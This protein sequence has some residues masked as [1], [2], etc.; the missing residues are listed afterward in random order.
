MEP[1]NDILSPNTIPLKDSVYRE[2]ADKSDTD[3]FRFTTPPYYRDIVEVEIENRS[4][5]LAPELHV[6]NQVKSEI[7]HRYD[8]TK[9][10]NL[11]YSF[12]AEPNSVYY[13]SIL[14]TILGPALDGLWWASLPR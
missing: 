7:A 2:I 1:N 10:A 11:R 13:E 9:G 5:T 12:P 4:T 14:Q 6:F 8:T 3:Y